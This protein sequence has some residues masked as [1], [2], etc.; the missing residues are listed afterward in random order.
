MRS[1]SAE[2]LK[3]LQ[4]SGTPFFLLDVREPGEFAAGKIAGAV[5]IPM[6]DVERRLRELPKDRDIVVMCH[7][8]ARSARITAVLNGLGY[9]NAANLAGGISAWSRRIDPQVSSGGPSLGGLL[10][11]LFGGSRP[12]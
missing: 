9:K 5:N 11:S 10:K 3:K 6:N 7:S 8:G 4:A 1:I 2:E 12:R